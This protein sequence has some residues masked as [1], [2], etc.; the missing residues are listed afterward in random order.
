LRCC[1][2]FKACLNIRGCGTPTLQC[3]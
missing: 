2:N 1:N 3:F